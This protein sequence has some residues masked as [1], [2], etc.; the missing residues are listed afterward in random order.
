LHELILQPDYRR[1]PEY[2]GAFTFIGPGQKTT[3]IGLTVHY[4]YRKPGMHW[5]ERERRE[6]L[7]AL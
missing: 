4:G 3:P 1:K 5:H 7:F 6:A 2:A